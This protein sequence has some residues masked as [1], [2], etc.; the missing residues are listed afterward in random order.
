MCVSALGMR[1]LTSL[2]ACG[3]RIGFGGAGSIQI[4]SISHT[5]GAW[6]CIPGR[7]VEESPVKLRHVARGE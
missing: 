5:L 6:R 1:A 7:E 2:V 4:R 3:A